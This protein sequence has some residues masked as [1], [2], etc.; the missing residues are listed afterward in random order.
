MFSDLLLVKSC[1]FRSSTVDGEDISEE[2][3]LS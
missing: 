2:I 1:L 3:V